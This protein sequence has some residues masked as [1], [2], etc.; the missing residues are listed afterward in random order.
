MS[1]HLRQ[2][3]LRTASL[4]LV[5]A[6]TPTAARAEDT[7]TLTRIDFATVVK[8]AVADGAVSRQ[9]QNGSAPRPAK[10]NKLKWIL[11]GA[12]GAAG[13]ALLAVGRGGGG[14]PSTPAEIHTNALRR[15]SFAPTMRATSSTVL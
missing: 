6:L 5:V 8:K 11:I 12:G 7:A 2:G 10:N 4:V 3:V 9:T 14:N 13:A 1:N 15:P